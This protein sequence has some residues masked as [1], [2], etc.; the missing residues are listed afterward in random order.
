[1]NKHSFRVIFSKTRGQLVVVGETAHS[2]SR[3]NRSG[4]LSRP[5]QL[6]RARALTLSILIGM[7]APFAMIG[8]ANAAGIEVDHSAPANQQATIGQAANGVTRVNIQ[9]PS[10]AGV[11]HN[12][13][14]RFDVDRPGVILNN[15]RV[16]VS[17]QLGGYV[18]GNPNLAHGSASVI[19]NEV[20]SADPSKLNG[21]IEVAGQKAQVIVANPAGI[22]CAGCGFINTSRSTLTTG[23]PQLENGQLKGYEVT[24]GTITVDDG[25]MNASGADYT[26]LI[27][28]AVKINAA[29]QAQNLQVVTGR[30]QVDMDGSATALSA[31]NDDKSDDSPEFSLDVAAVG[32]MYAGKIVLVGTE[33]GVGVN[34]AGDIGASTGNLKITADGQLINTGAISAGGNADIQVSGAVQ[35]QGTLY[36]A[37]SSKLAAD[38]VENNNILAAGN[39]LDVTADKINASENALTGAGIN[40]DLS[41][42]DHGSLTLTA[43]QVADHG[44][45]IAVDN[46]TVTTANADLSGSSIVAGKASITANNGDINIE[47]ATVEATQDATLSAQGDIN[48]QGG[49]LVA[50]GSVSL[51]ADHIDNRQGLVQASDTASIAASA[52][53]NSS[54]S[55]EGLGIRAGQVTVAADSLDNSDGFVGATGDVVLNGK[56]VSEDIPPVADAADTDDNETPEPLAVS[57]LSEPA[58]D[59]TQTDGETA[60]ASVP[61]SDVTDI[62]VANSNGQLESGHDLT[63]NASEISGEGTVAAENS[64]QLTSSHDL[65]NDSQLS[66]T[67]SA[68]VDVAGTFTNTGTV[69]AEQAL[70]VS[71]GD[72][73]NQST[74][75]LEATSTRIDVD[76][77]LSNRGVIDGSDTEI[78]AQ[79]VDNIGSG[80][81]YGDHL[82]IAADDIRNRAEDISETAAATA[83][84]TDDSTDADESQALDPDKGAT[85][86]SRERMDLAFTNLMNRD[87]AL[88]LSGGDMFMGR[89]LDEDSHASGQADSLENHSATIES[90]GNAQISVQQLMNK[91]DYY[92]IEKVLVGSESHTEYSQTRNTTH[93]DSSEVTLAG[94]HKNVSVPF[95]AKNYYVYNFTRSFYDDE[96][97]DAAPAR[98]SASG[99]M[100]IEAQNVTNDQSQILAGTDLNI[101]ADDI[102]N[103]EQVLN[104][105][106]EDVGTVHYSHLKKVR[107]GLHH[108]KKRRNGRAAAYD[109]GDQLDPINTVTGDVAVADSAR[110]TGNDDNTPGFSTSHALVTLSMEPQSLDLDDDSVADSVRTGGLISLADSSLFTVNTGDVSQ[111]LIETDPRFATQHGWL[112]SEYAL[113]Q[114]EEGNADVTQ[115]RLGDG[116]V[117]QQLIR[118]QITQLTGQRY[119]PG[120][121]NDEDQYRALMDAG[122]TAAGELDLTVGVALSDDEVRQL[123]SDIVW[124]VDETVTLADGSTQE[125]LVPKLYAVVKDDD[126]NG[127]GGLLAGNHVDLEVA[128]ALSNSGR[129]N[130]Q[131][132]NIAA[133][134]LDNRNGAV[135]GQEVEITT[136][137]DLNNTSGL[138]AARN[139]LDLQAG[140]DINVTTSSNEIHTRAGRNSYDR[141]NLGSTG[142]LLVTGDN[143]QLTAHANGNV[144]INAGA[145]INTGE[146]GTTT[147]SADNNLTLSDIKTHSRDAIYWK[148]HNHRV[149]DSTDSVGSALE[150]GDITL[151]AGNDLSTRNTTMSTD[152]ALDMEAG[153]NLDIAAGES[154][155]TIDDRHHFK[156][157]GFMSHTV[158]DSQYSSDETRAQASNIQAGTATLHAGNDVTVTG[159]TVTTDSGL[160]VTANNDIKV[161]AAED[162]DYSYYKH[163]KKKSGL[164]KGGDFGISVGTEQRTD[165]TRETRYSEV[166]ST[167]GTLNGDVALNADNDV[168]TRA[169]DL[170]AKGGNLSVE[171]DNVTLDAGYDQYHRHEE[172]KYKKTGVTLALSGGIVD[173]IEVVKNTI[174]ANKTTDNKKL[175]A[176]RDW[177]AA[178]KAKGV[179]QHLGNLANV[180][181]DFSHPLEKN[182]SGVP[183][184]ILGSLLD[185]AVASRYRTCSKLQPWAVQPWLKKMSLSPH[186]EIVTVRILAILPA[187]EPRF[188]AITLP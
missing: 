91:D 43:D 141:T 131:Q 6:P 129:I 162:S 47:N 27:A 54:T 99:Q 18:H 128:N 134:T 110:D 111:P 165:K 151:I 161:V 42:G 184:P 39:D 51:S 4:M 19:L 14:S 121:N 59:T 40:N 163:S 107:S 139:H 41:T 17:T 160:E 100:Q 44:E 37:K 21:F 183:V 38:V 10:S 116:Y 72:L 103:V 24:G 52:V 55:A 130:G 132:V 108:K 187:P 105:H 84:A 94:K 150:G 169:S 159:S 62:T 104:H 77:T 28:R 154:E 133:N 5:L 30:N 88:I 137:G 58:P 9:R 80:R 71:A 109:T 172:H 123:T 149:V 156:S 146:N 63:L 73:D 13:Y 87:A 93:Y 176:L 64:I 74:G 157:H 127:N 83:D 96:I 95:S 147:L 86:A 166:S 57:L 178:Q 185:Q 106:T 33:K 22:S 11:S 101:N 167:L 136:Q 142:T 45:N 188:R 124:M 168:T 97:D 182:N 120:Y 36:A 15:S 78:H 92:H 66:A 186:A 35:N 126:L 144:N 34:N 31:D 113:G 138:L 173:D 145:V 46:A 135:S 85:M 118:Q 81:I 60:D 125:V 53:D 29:V 3:N 175:E 98:L 180:G 102:D 115:K 67:N 122:V 69:A 70:S 181:D 2:E 56:A 68:T 75:D 164:M 143:A 117:E 23:R 20:N 65:H 16:D 12:Q 179:E 177:G 48:K 152:G 112:N 25:G 140:G 158:K 1:M 114:L 76:N 119:L 90:M 50:G 174:D 148:H 26:Q 171:G 89:T 32:G 82:A 7:G 8:Q 153:H 61:P 170:L 49:T 79:T 155:E